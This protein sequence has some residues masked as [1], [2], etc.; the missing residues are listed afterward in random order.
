MTKEF[1]VIPAGSCWETL[2]V[3]AKKTILRSPTKRD[4]VHRTFELAKKEEK[5]KVVVLNSEGYVEEERILENDPEK[6]LKDFLSL[7]YSNLEPA[8]KE[9]VL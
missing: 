1:R 4:L 5:C 8:Y 7:Y 9:A 6:K 3:T 2:D